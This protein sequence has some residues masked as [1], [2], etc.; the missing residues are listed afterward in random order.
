MNEIQLKPGW[1]ARDVDRAQARVRQWN[2]SWR[3][4]NG[5]VETPGLV[6]PRPSPVHTS[7]RPNAPGEAPAGCTGPLGAMAGTAIVNGG[8]ER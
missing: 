7:R 4:V 2:A 8:S 6:T 3:R 5:L 1:L